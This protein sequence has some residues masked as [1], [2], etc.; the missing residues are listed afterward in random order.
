VKLVVA[1]GTGFVGRHLARSLLEAG[2]E[3]TVLGRNPSRISSIPMLQ[4]ADAVRGD[5]TDPGSLTGA[6]DGAEGVVGAV[7]FPGYPAEVPRAGLT[8][9]AYDRAG[10]ENLVAE[11]KR[12]GVER[13]LY[14]SGANSTPSAKENWYRAKGRAEETLRSSGLRFLILRPSWAY[15]PGDRAVNTY[16]A[17]ARFSPVIPMIARFEGRRMIPQLIQPVFIEDVAL[18]VQRAFDR[19]EAW[20]SSY[21][22][23]GPDVM[24]MRQVIE[25]V[26]EVTGKKRTIIPVPDVLA[27]AG[28]TPL[29]LI[30]RPLMTPSAIDF[31][32]Q[33]GLVD[34]TDLERDLDVHP[35]PLREG[36]SRYMGR[37]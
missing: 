25:T 23:G 20:N 17:M 15:G 6:L 21:E 12:A 27:K 22:I 24:T 14:I 5:V 34:I 9:D 7:Q 33:D 19:P 32:T 28:V 18:A 31:V 30:P 11:A 16:A 3:V 4:G 13:Y 37:G 10:T 1:G 2:H 29:A 26:L 35:V 36:L 8:F